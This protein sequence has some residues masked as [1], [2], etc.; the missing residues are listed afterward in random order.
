MNIDIALSKL[1]NVIDI[2]KSYRQRT[3]ELKTKQR[4]IKTTKCSFTSANVIIDNAGVFHVKII[5]VNYTFIVEQ[6][7]KA[8]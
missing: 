1:S 5:N 7:P 6:K 2:I 8:H 4:G 3:V